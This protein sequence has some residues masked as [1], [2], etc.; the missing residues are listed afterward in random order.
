LYFAARPGSLEAECVR[1]LGVELDTLEAEF[2]T[3]VE[4]LAGRNPAGSSG[5]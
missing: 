3:A 1:Q 2:W 5:G 4:R